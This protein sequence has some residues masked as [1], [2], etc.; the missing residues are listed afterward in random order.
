[1][2]ALRILPCLALTGLVGCSD[3]TKTFNV[4]LTPGAETPPCADAGTAA[5]GTATVVVASDNS[6]IAVTETYSGL[7]GPPTAAHLH[8]GTSAAPGP[9]VLPFTVGLTTSPFSQTFT[10][11]DYV[12]ASGAPADFPTF[13]TAL[14]GGGAAYANI[15][16]DACKPGEIRGEIQ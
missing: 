14:R 15:H 1:M 16:T 12:A 4:T 2:N 5:T 7:S 6:S 10:A 13:V 8:S 11:A 3:D 9:V